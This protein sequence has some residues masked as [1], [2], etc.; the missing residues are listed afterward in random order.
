MW[1]RDDKINIIPSVQLIMINL[2]KLQSVFILFFLETEAHVG[3][4][5]II[6][7]LA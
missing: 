4:S 1:R 5:H 6:S 7:S 2:I 3:R